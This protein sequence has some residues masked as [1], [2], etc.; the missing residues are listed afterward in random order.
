[1]VITVLLGLGLLPRRGADST[2]R[3]GGE[4][5]KNNGNISSREF[6]SNEN[7]WI[8]NQP[9]IRKM[10]FQGCWPRAPRPPAARRPRSR[11]RGEGDE[12]VRKLWPALR[13][14]RAPSRAP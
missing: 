7:H 4:R 10:C 3:L 5:Q 14:V 12:T 1:M 8:G 6:S 9:L 13:V 2:C 11:L